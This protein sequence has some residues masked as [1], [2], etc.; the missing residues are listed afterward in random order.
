VEQYEKLIATFISLRKTLLLLGVTL[1]SVTLLLYILSPQIF[2]FMQHHLEQKLAFYSVAEPFLAHVKLAF[3]SALF[4][5]MPL[6][7]HVLWGALALPFGLTAASRFLFTASTVGLFY[8][9][10]LFCYFVT[11]PF[12]V[13]FLLSFGSRTL[14]PL[15]SIDKF[16][17]FIAIFI[18]AFGVIFELPVFMV[19]C[20]R[21][22]ICPRRTF[23]KNRRYALLIIS[24]AAALLTP[25]PDVVNMMLMGGPLYLLYEAGIL[26][27]KIMGYK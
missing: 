16:V 17:S 26:V 12:G 14:Q 21:A 22:G 7:L 20:S 5:L 1:C 4:L 15:I 13:R 18:L 3:F 6:L 25:T 24:I 8:A 19:F 9:G 23:E 27:T 10:S 2:A 11:L